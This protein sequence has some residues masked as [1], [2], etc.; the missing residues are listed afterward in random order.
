MQDG[1]DNVAAIRRDCDAGDILM[2]IH[3]LL[4]EKGASVSFLFHGE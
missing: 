2:E 3:K 4:G 1:I